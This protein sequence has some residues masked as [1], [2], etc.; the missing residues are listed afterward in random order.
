MYR[1]IPSKL[2]GLYNLE[3]QT[4]NGQFKIFIKL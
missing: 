2:K 4:N 1:K 3:K